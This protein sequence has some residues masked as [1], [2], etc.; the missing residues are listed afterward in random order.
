MRK[1]RKKFKYARLPEFDQGKPQLSIEGMAVGPVTLVVL[2]LNILLLLWAMSSFTF[3]PSYQQNTTT[4]AEN[5]W[6]DW[7]W[8]S[9]R[10]LESHLLTVLYN[11]LF[12]FCLTLF[13]GGDQGQDIHVAVKK[14]LSIWNL[15]LDSQFIEDFLVEIKLLKYANLHKWK[16]FSVFRFHL[17]LFICSNVAWAR[18]CI[19]GTWLSTVPW[20]TTTY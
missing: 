13:R 16:S 3:W 10:S 11:R 12:Y 8:S 7:Y 15:T 18:I 1:R 6:S 9:W 2:F 20:S 5:G 19:N 4:Y 14:L 17:F